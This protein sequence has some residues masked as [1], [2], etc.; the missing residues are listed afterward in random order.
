MVDRKIV[1]YFRLHRGN[2]K[3]GDLKKKV[4]SEGYT[5]KDVDDAIAQLDR[6]S[7]GSVP[8]VKATVNKI[9]TMNFTVPNSGGNVVSNNNDNNLNNGGL[10][11]GNLKNQ[12]VNDQGVNGVKKGKVKKG[13]KAVVKKKKKW[14]LALVLSVLLGW[15]GVDR[16]YAGYVLLGVLKLVTLGGL[17]V[18]WLIDIFLI[19]LK[20]DFSRAIWV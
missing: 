6:Q 7:G 9:N 3:I 11:K 4:L 13:K 12:G 20:K 18:W 16:F 5:Q 17:G 8:T 10:N 19:I 1:E 2:Y 14:V 15:L